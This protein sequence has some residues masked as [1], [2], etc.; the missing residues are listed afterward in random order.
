MRR[1]QPGSLTS[2]W[3]NGLGVSGEGRLSGDTP[4][5]ED[6]HLKRAERHK[7]IGDLLA[8][9]G[10]E[11]AAVPWFYSAYHL[12]K[13]ALLVDPIFDDLRA[14]SAISVDLIPQDR[15]TNRHNG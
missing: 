6:E 14:L 5:R 11:W 10:D 9:A 1:S 2:A 15:F 3:P 7:K 13:A 4:L 8:G 12:V